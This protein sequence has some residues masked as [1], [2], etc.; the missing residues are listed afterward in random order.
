MNKD[1]L[2]ERALPR[3]V[4]QDVL[5]L[6]NLRRFSLFYLL[7]WFLILFGI[8]GSDVAVVSFPY[9]IVYVPLLDFSVSLISLLLF[10][11]GVI[12]F[13]IGFLD[14]YILYLSILTARKTFTKFGLG[15]I[16]IS[17]PSPIITLI[18]FLIL[19]TFSL[20]GLSPPPITI[21]QA[22]LVVIVLGIFLFLLGIIQG[23]VNIWRLGN[24]YYSGLMKISSILLIIPILGAPLLNLACSSLLSE[25][26][27]QT[28]SVWGGGG[29]NE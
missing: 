29:R 1:N 2:G 8:I 15:L 25:I 13:I 17:L 26:N 14:L 28:C 24:R 19:I 7:S 18:G 6:R 4:A 11:V 3:Y 23:I 16:V 27:S 9:P 22:S 5:I 12:G 10:I 20:K 21:L